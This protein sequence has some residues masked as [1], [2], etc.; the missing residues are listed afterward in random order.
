MQKQTAGWV[1]PLG[2]P[3]V[4]W[5]LAKKQFLPQVYILITQIRANWRIRKCFRW[6]GFLLRW[7]SPGG[8]RTFSGLQFLGD[9]VGLLGRAGKSTGRLP[10]EA[11]N[12]GVSP[13]CRP[14]AL[15]EEKGEKMLPC[16]IMHALLSQWIRPLKRWAAAKSNLIHK[17]FFFFYI[18][19][20]PSFVHKQKLT[21]VSPPL[22]QYRR[23]LFTCVHSSGSYANSSS[24]F[25]IN[26]GPALMDLFLIC[27]RH[28][29][30][31]LKREKYQS[32]HSGSPR[33]PGPAWQRA[34]L[35]PSSVGLPL[36][37]HWR[38]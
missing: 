4:A 26:S 6:R 23:P 16:P 27:C 20:R 8:R 32:L 18:V 34:S 13:Q 38:V 9:E 10:R 22:L 30:L 12:Q 37:C 11:G 25:K 7:G 36:P 28:R 3:I 21:V 1:W 2:W 14:V 19:M 35:L 5:P 29:P 17:T 15:R 31:P 24:W 33:S